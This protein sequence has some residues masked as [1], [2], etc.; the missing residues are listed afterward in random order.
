[1]A[2]PTRKIVAIGGGV[3]KTG[4]T[5]AIDKEII[6]LSQKKRPKLLFLPTATSDSKLYWK[7]VDRHFGTELGCKTDVLYLL[8]ETPSP[9][10]IGE[11]ILGTDIIYV[12]GGNTLKMMRRWRWLGVDKLLKT[13]WQRGIVLSGIS[14][15][16]ICWF[17]SGHS[18]SRSF[19]NPKEWKYINVR[20]LGFLKGIHCPHYNGSTLGTPRRV[21]FRP[22]I[23][24]AGGIGIAIENNCAIAFLD[25]QY[26]VITSKQNAKAYRV[27]KKDGKVQSERIPQVQRRTPIARL[28]RQG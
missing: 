25:D 22:M 8:K 27:F 23:Q 2:N 13:A 6:R 26:R 19:Y 7:H 14:A 15:G 3:M 28:F 1:M 10:A 4:A 21:H 16:S 12:G 24:K 9:K 20:G 17:D 5:M 11:A 18:D